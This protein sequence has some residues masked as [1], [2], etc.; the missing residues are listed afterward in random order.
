MST[1]ANAIVGQKRE[2]DGGAVQRLEHVGTVE[3]NELET[4][5]GLA[6]VDGTI[7]IGSERRSSG[8]ES[9]A[10]RGLAE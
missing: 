1:A 7:D 5:V 4:P 2:V 8:G 3:R 9:H 10:T 6:G